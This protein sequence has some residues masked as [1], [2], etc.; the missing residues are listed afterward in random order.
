MK[1]FLTDREK[2]LIR[3]HFGSRGYRVLFEGDVIHVEKD[4][5]YL[6][7]DDTIVKKPLEDFLKLVSIGGREEDSE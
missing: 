6:E 1:T 4:T 7:K 5:V 3:K 2:R